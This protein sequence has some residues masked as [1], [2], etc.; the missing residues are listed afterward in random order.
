MPDIL[1][2]TG[3]K[4]VHNTNN[5]RV[6][7]FDIRG[8]EVLFSP[9]V[10]YAP[11]FSPSKIFRENIGTFLGSYT[12]EHFKGPSITSASTVSVAENST[13]AH[14]LTGTDPVRNEGLTWSISGGAD[15]GQLEIA[16]STLRWS[17]NGTRDFEAPADADLNN[18]YVV[19]VQARDIDGNTVN[20]TVSVTV[21][22]VAG[23]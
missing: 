4:Y 20:Q 5:R 9:E 17:A 6:L 10:V 21:T 12:R 8:D 18:V 22:D 3:N 13:L 7:V 1:P 11:D 16:G 14:T 19:T 15:A 2:A 23:A